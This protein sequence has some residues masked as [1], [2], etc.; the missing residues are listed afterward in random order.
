MHIN[1][2]LILSMSGFSSNKMATASS[3]NTTI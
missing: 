3:V 2:F 1:T